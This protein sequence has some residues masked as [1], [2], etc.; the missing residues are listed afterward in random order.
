MSQKT[1]K[2]IIVSVK[3]EFFTTQWARDF[4]DQERYRG[5]ITGW[6]LKR[7]NEVWIKWDGWATNRATSLSTLDGVDDKGASVEARLHDYKDGN[8]APVYIEPEQ[9]ADGAGGDADDADGAGADV[10]DDDD[11]HLCEGAEGA[12]AS[13][14]VIGQ[15]CGGGTRAAAARGT[16]PAAAWGAR[17]SSS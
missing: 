9:D 12:R 2:G 16:R 11:T 10:V 15:V 8:A 5:E 17:S 6:K 13:E 1:P 7:N 4:A 14:S 3:A